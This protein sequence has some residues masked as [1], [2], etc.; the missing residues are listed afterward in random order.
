MPFW[1][2]EVIDPMLNAQTKREI[3]KQ[4]VWIA[5]EPSNPDPFVNLAALYR[6]QNRPDEALGLLLEAVRLDAG[7]AEAN[8]SLCEMYSVAGDYAAA[9]RHARQA[10]AAG[11]ASGVEL[12]A[13]HG[14]AE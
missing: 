6:T 8:L 12:L 11:D 3:D 7:H 9:W 1:R 2:N 4:M 13:R 5:R 10:D 14:I